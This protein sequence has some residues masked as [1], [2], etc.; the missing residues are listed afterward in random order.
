MADGGDA[1]VGGSSDGADGPTVPGTPRDA[2]AMRPTREAVQTRLEGL[3]RDNRFIVAV[4]F[5][6]VG[7]VLL[8]AILLYNTRSNIRQRV[9]AAEVSQ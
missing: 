7:A 5:P 3:V 4:V 1:D 2:L 8:V 6:A 9:L